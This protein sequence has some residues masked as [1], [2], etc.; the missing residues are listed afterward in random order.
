ML[1]SRYLP[2]GCTHG[3]SPVAPSGQLAPVGYLAEAIKQYL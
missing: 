2:V 3:Y 1:F